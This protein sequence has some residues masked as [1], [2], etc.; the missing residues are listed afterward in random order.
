MEHSTRI[1]T[2]PSKQLLHI[3]FQNMK[4]FRTNT[5]L[6]CL[7]VSNHRQN[8]KQHPL[9]HIIP[10]SS[11]L[12]LMLNGSHQAMF[13]QIHMYPSNQDSHTS[14]Q[15]S[16]SHQLL[17]TSHTTRSTQLITPPQL[18][19][20]LLQLITQPPPPQQLLHIT[21]RLLQLLITKKINIQV[22]NHITILNSTIWHTLRSSLQLFT[23]QRNHQNMNRQN[24]SHQKWSTNTNPHH[25]K[26]MVL[27]MKHPI[28]RLLQLPNM[29]QQL[30]IMSQ[31]IPPQKSLTSQPTRN[32][33]HQSHTNLPTK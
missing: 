17:H 6:L 18:Q 1:K 30:R 8:M 26:L 2:F 28:T 32:Q 12:Q 19:L 10:S 3:G 31:L 14:P 33:Q 9:S 25:T 11:N 5:I 4:R 23:T 21:P 7:L 15:S 16:L 29:H 20:Q 27:F 13:H 22:K 24:T